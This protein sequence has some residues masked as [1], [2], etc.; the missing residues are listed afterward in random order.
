MSLRRQSL[1]IFTDKQ[2]KDCVSDRGEET[3]P[4]DPND[5]LFLVDYSS[6]VRVWSERKIKMI[7]KQLKAISIICKQQ[8]QQSTSNH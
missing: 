7:C 1:F 2:N 8:K 4:R 3:R 5:E 6:V